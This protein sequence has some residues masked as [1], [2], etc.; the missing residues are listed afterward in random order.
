MVVNYYL[1]SLGFNFHEDEDF[2]VLIREITEYLFEATKDNPL[3]NWGVMAICYKI[4]LSAVLTPIP[5]VS[6]GFSDL[7]A[8]GGCTH[9]K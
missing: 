7:V 3:S 1:I 6:S 2:V 4:L 5:T 9:N 8:L